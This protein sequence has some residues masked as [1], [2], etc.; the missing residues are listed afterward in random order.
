MS[1]TLTVRHT[2]EDYAAWRKV[3]DETEVLRAQYGC[4]A[5][6]VMQLPADGNDLFITH[7]FPTVEQAEGFAHDP[8]LREAMGRAGVRGVPQIEIFTDV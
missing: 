3:Y 6:R 4:T 2:V 7:E 5:Q 1:A 8:S